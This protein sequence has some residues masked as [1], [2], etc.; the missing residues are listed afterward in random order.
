MDN[1]AVVLGAIL[2]AIGVGGL[3]V[4]A[5]LGIAVL[6]NSVRLWWHVRRER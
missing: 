4:A 6:W 2:G 5:C 3:V 1:I